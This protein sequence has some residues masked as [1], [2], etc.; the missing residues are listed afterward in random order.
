MGRE[1]IIGEKRDRKEDGRSGRRD[2]LSEERREDTWKLLKSGYA[3]EE[4]I[5]DGDGGVACL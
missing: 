1:G 3:V 2:S 4:G 5:R